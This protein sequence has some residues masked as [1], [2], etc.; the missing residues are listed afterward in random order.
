MSFRYGQIPSSI[1]HGNDDRQE[2]KAAPLQCTEIGKAEEDTFLKS[3][4]IA[5]GLEPW[6]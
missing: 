2:R 5:L 1:R 6:Y 3:I 4:W